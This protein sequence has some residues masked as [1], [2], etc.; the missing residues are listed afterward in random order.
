MR[1]SIEG[2]H[3]TAQTG[4]PRRPQQWPP[5]K[6]AET[7]ASELYDHGLSSCLR[8]GGG[9]ESRPREPGALA[10]PAL[11]RVGPEPPRAALAVLWPGDRGNGV[12][13]PPARQKKAVRSQHLP[14]ATSTRD[15]RQP[16]GSSLTRMM[17]LSRVTEPSV[18]VGEVLQLSLQGL[19][20]AESTRGPPTLMACS[21]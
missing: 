15:V 10:Q 11:P 19:P 12:W 18:L 14:E 9:Q 20:T 8:W 4:S 7:G 21:A 17:P 3:Q 5:W 2:R 16:V 1:P 13:E 6:D